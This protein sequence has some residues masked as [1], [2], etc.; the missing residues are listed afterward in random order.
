[1]GS[2][3]TGPSSA[4]LQIQQPALPARAAPQCW[5]PLIKHRLAIRPPTIVDAPL[6]RFI[7]PWFQRSVGVAPVC[8]QSHCRHSTK[9]CTDA[10]V[11]AGFDLCGFS[12]GICINRTSQC[13]TTDTSQGLPCGT[14]FCSRDGGSCVD[15]C[16]CEPAPR[17]SRMPL[18]LLPFLC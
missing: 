17:T 2:A 5:V 10:S 4:V 8:R 13:C 6:V 15:S 11:S 14:K 9:D 16:G 1:M 18:T 3:S 7:C 12:P